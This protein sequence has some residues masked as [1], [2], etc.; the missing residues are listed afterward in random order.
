MNYFNITN[1]VFWFYEENQVE[2][3]DVV[4]AGL[5]RNIIRGPSLIIQSL[6]SYAKSPIRDVSCSSFLLFQRSSPGRA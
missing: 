4:W 1:A 2:H 3:I 6:I 5:S